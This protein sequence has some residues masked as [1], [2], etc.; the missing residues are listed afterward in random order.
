M[1]VKVYTLGKIRLLIIGIQGVHRNVLR[2]T[3]LLLE[4]TSWSNKQVMQNG[5][6]SDNLSQK[7]T[8]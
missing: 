4:F 7:Q 1:S 3:Y 8:M 2:E 5:V 6:L